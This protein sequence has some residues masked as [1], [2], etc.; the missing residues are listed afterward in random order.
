MELLKITLLQAHN[1]SIPVSVNGANSL[2]VGPPGLST[3]NGPLSKL[4]LNPNLLMSGLSPS[5]LVSAAAAAVASGRSQ[6][7]LHPPT[8]N[9]SGPVRRRISDKASLSLSGGK[10]NLLFIII[11]YHYY[12]C[13]WYKNMYYN[14]FFGEKK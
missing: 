13:S 5:G 1:C 3:G 14:F 12:H 8:Q 11:L 7:I 4:A 6:G 2:C 9:L 10:L